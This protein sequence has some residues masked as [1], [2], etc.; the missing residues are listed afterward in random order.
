M[1]YDTIR[2]TA[3]FYYE[4][5]DAVHITLNSNKFYNGII[6][7]VKLDRLILK[8]EVLGEIPV[9]FSEVTEIEPRIQKG[10]RK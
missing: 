7:E 9:F 5:K 6:L 10:E 4:Y 1:E 8:D 2:E 3:L